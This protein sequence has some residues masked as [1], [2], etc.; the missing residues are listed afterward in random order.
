LSLSEQRKVVCPLFLEKDTDLEEEILRGVATFHPYQCANEDEVVRVVID[1][2]AVITGPIEVRKKAISGMRK[3]KMIQALGVGFDRI[4][5]KTAGEKG[6]FVCNVPDYCV[7]EVADHTIGLL[8]AANRRLL[9]LI[10]AAK[11]GMW[12]SKLPDQVSTPVLGLHGKTIGIVGLGRIGTA[13]AIRAKA[14]GM[15][16]LFYDPYLRLGIERSLGLERSETLE[17]LLDNSDV[18][19]IHTPLTDETRHM[20]QEDELRRMK[21]HALIINTARG[22]IVDKMALLK[23]LREKWIA[24]AALDVIE[25]EPPDQTEPLLSLDNLT[26]TPHRAYY[27]EESNVDCRRK[28][29]MNVLRVLDGKIPLHIVNEQFLRGSSER[30]PSRKPS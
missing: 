17:C 10:D 2:D 5:L 11:R 24:G 19:T 3:C 28:A 6:I 30:Q 16:V 27:S 26:I 7:N 23:A 29:A 25:D 15:R 8:L 9:D 21:K 18:V 22:A 13:V 1:A 14:F 20:I 12:F 4:D